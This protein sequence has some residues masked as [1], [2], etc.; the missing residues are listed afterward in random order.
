MDGPNVNWSVQGLIS[1]EC[2]KQE[3]P[4]MINSG[5]C[6]LHNVHRAF[7]SGMEAKGFGNCF[8]ILLYREI[9]RS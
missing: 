5:S 2:S 7:K 9:H 6:S 8:M 4:D 3:F 1:E